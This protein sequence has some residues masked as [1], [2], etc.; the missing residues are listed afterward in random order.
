MENQADMPVNEPGQNGVEA[1]AISAAA[2]TNSEVGTA[3]SEEMPTE[4]QPA[5]GGE[6]VPLFD[7]LSAQNKKK[8]EY[9]RHVADSFSAK[10]MMEPES[11]QR[12]KFPQLQ[13]EITQQALGKL[14][15]LKD[16]DLE[17]SVEL[18]NTV[19]TVEKIIA[20]NVGS[21]IELNQSVGDQ[22]RLLINGNPYAYG[23]VVVIG[24]KFGVRITKI[25]HEP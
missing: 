6:A 1:A 4:V 13:E 19:L 9:N 17:A 12:A 24:D 16:V 2:Q 11:V 5:E 14:E 25:I 23:E 8:K 10:V 3:P 18:G 22:V 15:Y 21:I 20:L 7:Q